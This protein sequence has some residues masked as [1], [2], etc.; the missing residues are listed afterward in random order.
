[1]FTV[2]LSNRLIIQDHGTEY[3]LNGLAIV[4]SPHQDD[5]SIGM[6][7]TI[8]LLIKNGFIVHYIFTTIESTDEAIFRK[9]EAEAAIS[10]LG[11]TESKIYFLDFVD[12]DSKIFTLNFS[13]SV[14]KLKKK[15]REIELQNKVIEVEETGKEILIDN[16]HTIILTTSRHDAH[17]DHEETFNMIK[18]GTRKKIILEFPVVNHM[19]SAFKCNSFIEIPDDVYEAKRKALAQYVG[20]DNKGRIMWE[21]IEALMLD[22]GRIIGTK[23]AESCFVSWYGYLKPLN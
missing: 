15:I 7:G 6:G 16:K 22:N 20:E 1:M 13:E 10:E 9:D 4:V 8:S 23:R 3:A 5:E 17:R 12:G 19:S 11:M 2:D 14:G 21:D 18:N